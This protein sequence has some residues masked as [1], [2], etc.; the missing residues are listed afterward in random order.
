VEITLR[1]QI[2]FPDPV[3]YGHLTDTLTGQIHVLL[4]IL[5]DPDSPPYLAHVFVISRQKQ[6]LCKQ[7]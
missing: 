1:H 7:A 5:N 4:Y 6:Q 2:N 3:L